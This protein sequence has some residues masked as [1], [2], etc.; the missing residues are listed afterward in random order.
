MTLEQKTFVLGVGAQKAGTSWVRNYL[1][2]RTDV[3][4]A[5]AEMH[6]FDSRYGIDTARRAERLLARK[7][8]DTERMSELLSLKLGYL[9]GSEGG[10]LYKEF[11]NARVPEN[12]DVFGE[13]TPSYALV[14]EAGYRAVL[15]IFPNSKVFFIMRDPAERFYSQIRMNRNRRPKKREAAFEADRLSQRAR[16][17]RRSLYELTIRDLDRVFPPQNIL[18]LFYERLFQPPAIEQL[19]RF[20]CVPYVPADFDELVNAGGPR[21][22]MPKD[23]DRAVRASFEPT[24]TFCKDRFGHEFPSEW[25]CP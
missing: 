20:L 6:Y 10:V 7:N 9:E 17:D 8:G 11:F 13:I 14:G 19:C 2:G 5:P 22:D 3:Y 18:Y 15:D 24:Y 25:R 12:I 21:E 16:G 23:I 1:R 4:F